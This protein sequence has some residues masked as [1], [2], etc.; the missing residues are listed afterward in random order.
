MGELGPIG[1]RPMNVLPD[2]SSTVDDRRARH[3]ERVL[4]GECK[5]V[6]SEEAAKPGDDDRGSHELQKA[7]A[8]D[9]ECLVQETV[10]IRHVRDTFK[11]ESPAHRDHGLN[12]G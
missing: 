12:V 9:V 2:D 1:G 6:P 5:P 4:P 7:S 11:P 10:G 8:L 3:L